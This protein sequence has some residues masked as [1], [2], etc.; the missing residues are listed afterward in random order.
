MRQVAMAVAIKAWANN[1]A[2]IEILIGDWYKK[3]I[4][5]GQELR[6][7]ERDVKEGRFYINK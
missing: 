1:G 3:T 2:S 6:L 5:T 7:S 4:L